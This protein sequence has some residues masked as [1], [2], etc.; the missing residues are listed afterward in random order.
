ML[1]LALA[2]LL[3][4][5]FWPRDLVDTVEGGLGEAE[6]SELEV[7]VLFP[8]PTLRAWSI[9]DEALIEDFLATLEGRSLRPEVVTPGA[10]YGQVD[11]DPREP[12]TVR[13]HVYQDAGNGRALTRIN[14]F[15]GRTNLIVEIDGASYVLYGDGAGLMW[16]L[17]RYA[18]QGRDLPG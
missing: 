9:E 6:I 14:F 15:D 17:L 5:A 3:V 8:G 12:R 13:V 16:D 18:E 7:Q 2:A 10:R 4:F 11:R 1:G